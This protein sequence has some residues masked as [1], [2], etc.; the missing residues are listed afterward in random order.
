MLAALRNELHARYELLVR[1]PA[2]FHCFH[3]FGLLSAQVPEMAI[4]LTFVR[5]QKRG[6]ETLSSE[7]VESIQLSSTEVISGQSTS[8]D[9]TL[10]I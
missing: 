9:A 8:S 7:G 4:I 1:N 3:N 6:S 10:F 5:A 2:V